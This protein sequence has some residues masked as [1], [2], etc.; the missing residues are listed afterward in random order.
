MSVSG[1]ELG[2]R[3][4]IFDIVCPLRYDILV[5]A[6]FIELLAKNE[7]LLA[8]ELEELLEHRAARSY[9]VW[10]REV[11]IKRFASEIYDDKKLV[12]QRFVIRV[13]KT[14][15]LWESIHLTGFDAAHPITLRSGK[16]ILQVN[17]KK[18]GASLFAGEGCHRIACLL[19]MGK[20]YLEPNEYRVAIQ[21]KFQPLDN[22]ALLLDKLPISV[23][24]YL[25]F[26]SRGYC[27]GQTL[28]TPNEAVAYLEENDSDRLPELKSIFEHDLIRLT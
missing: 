2:K 21:S 12:R 20:K 18:I 6:E 11:C 15:R 22:T 1:D 5:R 19:V 26:I 3:I 13:E 28:A 14:K 4:R 7:E 25:Q 16:S 17:G 23:A 27:A 24:D 10:F 9:A 8:S